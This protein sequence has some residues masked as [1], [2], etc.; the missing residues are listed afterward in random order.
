MADFEKV[1]LIKFNTTQAQRNLRRL[2]VQMKGIERSTRRTGDGFKKDIDKRG[3]RAFKNVQAASRRT[4]KGIKRIGTASAK[5]AWINKKMWKGAKRGAD[6]AR[7]A[8]EKYNKSLGRGK[9]RGKGRGIGLMG[10]GA[11][12][13]G[14]Y[15][16]GRGL[17]GS[18]GLSRE[19]SKGMAQVSTLIP[20]NVKR[21]NELRESIM[22]LSINTGKPLDDL[23][24]GLYQMISAFGDSPDTMAKMDIATKASVAGV[25]TTEDAINLLAA[26]TKGY[27]DESKE[28]TKKAADLAFKTVELGQTTFPELA[29][30]MGKVIPLAAALGTSQ[31]ELFAA[32]A[33]LTG[34][35]GN[36]AE[37]STQLTSVYSGLLKPTE[38]MTALAKK[39]G[40]ESAVQMAKARGLSGVFEI[41]TKETKGNEEALGELLGRKEGIVAMMALN[42]KSADT[43]RQKLEKLRKE[44]VD[45]LGTAY[46]E[47]VDGIDKEGHKLDI[48]KRRI[49]VLGASI[50]DVLIPLLGD[51]AQAWNTLFDTISEGRKQEAKDKETVDP[52]SDKSATKQAEEAIGKDLRSWEL[53]QLSGELED[54]LE[55]Q[56]VESRHAEGFFDSDE[57]KQRREAMQGEIS[58]AIT[59]LQPEIRKQ[60]QSER[61]RFERAELLAEGGVV[62]GRGGSGQTT[63]NQTNNITTGATQK[64]V[65][66]ALKKTI[67]NAGK[68]LGRRTQNL[69]AASI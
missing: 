22:K 5:A 32:M 45:P 37:V 13:L 40:Y 60:K 15:A 46:K 7:A 58:K 43:F 34:V 50:G 28:A 17:R 18:V 67:D 51:A 61:E 63:I 6:K 16:A 66:R 31:E 48:A 68:D 21:V 39:Y 64:D 35:T 49:E 14:I 23:T 57:D 27:G 65:E 54:A 47:M 20:G 52:T 8:T 62:G 38:E 69:G 3:V 42:G 56:K 9:G 10:A 53:E 44:G 59:L 25:S 41:L 1:Y 30:S 11:A 4:E 12:G 19:F 36:T 24:G 29:A 55:R 26:V 2:N 33:T